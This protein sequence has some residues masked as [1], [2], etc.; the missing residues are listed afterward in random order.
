MKP[1]EITAHRIHEVIQDA[2]DAPPQ[3]D[4]ERAATEAVLRKLRGPGFTEFILEGKH[5]WSDDDE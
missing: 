3:T 4:E 1:R 2:M 5:E